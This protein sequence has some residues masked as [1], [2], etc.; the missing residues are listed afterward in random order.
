MPQSVNGRSGKRKKCLCGIRT[1]DCPAQSL[2]NTQA[3][4]SRFLHR[5]NKDSDH[6]NSNNFNKRKT[7]YVL[8]VCRKYEEEIPS[9]LISLVPCTTLKAGHENVSLRQPD[10]SHCNVKGKMSVFALV[11]PGGRAV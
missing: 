11:I 3:E 2:L 4:I 7:I 9:H 6:N 1:P 10:L 8:V 5:N